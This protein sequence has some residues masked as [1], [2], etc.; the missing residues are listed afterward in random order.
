MRRRRLNLRPAPAHPLAEACSSF[1]REAGAPRPPSRGQ[2]SGATLAWMSGRAHPFPPASCQGQSYA[3]LNCRGQKPLAE[4]AKKD[5]GL[6][7][8]SI[9][10][11]FLR[12]SSP[13]ASAGRTSASLRR[14]AISPPGDQGL[15]GQNA[16][17]ARRA[18]KN[19][20]TTKIATTA[21]PTA[22]MGRCDPG[23]AAL[24]LAPSG[25]ADL[26]SASMCSG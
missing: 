1:G 13:V 2:S 6:I 5:N 20:P 22:S 15:A 25:G 14:R 24:A 26:S 3:K 8:L 10:F 16:V 18:R 4:T 19:R 12:I 21:A 23:R 9:F 11:T 17:T 7:S